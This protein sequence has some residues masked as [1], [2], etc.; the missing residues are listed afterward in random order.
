[1]KYIN[2]NTG[3]EV[4]ED[5]LYEVVDTYLS[6]DDYE[7]KLNENESPVRILGQEYDFGRCLRAVDPL[8]FSQLKDEYIEFV[9]EELK[10]GYE[11]SEVPVKAVKEEE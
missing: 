7:R 8:Y 4:R 11:V 1:M 10:H 2:K 9:I 5:D 3:Q 6:D